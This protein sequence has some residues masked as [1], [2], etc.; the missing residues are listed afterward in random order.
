MATSDQYVVTVCQSTYA[1]L[2][3]GPFPTR[4]AATAWACE[5]DW[6]WTKEQRWFVVLIHPQTT[7]ERKWLGP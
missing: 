3:L 2:V 4:E 6:Q 1:P 5:Y 7:W